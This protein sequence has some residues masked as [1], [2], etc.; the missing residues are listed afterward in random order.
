VTN[1]DSNSVVVAVSLRLTTHTHICHS[2]HPIQS[3][4][5]LRVALA[6][7]A[8]Q[9]PSQKESRLYSCSTVISGPLRVAALPKVRGSEMIEP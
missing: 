7:S 4:C 6:G 5:A 1:P 2:A 3:F 9:A 8:A